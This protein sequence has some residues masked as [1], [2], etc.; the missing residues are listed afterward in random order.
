MKSGRN[1]TRLQESKLSIAAGVR[2]VSPADA[3]QVIR[4]SMYARQTVARDR[5]DCAVDTRRARVARPPPY[6]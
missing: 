3:N 5:V 2:F 1:S 6:R 4:A